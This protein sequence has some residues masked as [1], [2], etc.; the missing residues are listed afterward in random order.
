MYKTCTV[1]P[2][3]NFRYVFVWLTYRAINMSG[4]W[5]RPV[6]DRNFNF[7]ELL[8]NVSSYTE[9]R[10]CS[11]W[12]F[13]VLGGLSLTALLC[14]CLF[15]NYRLL[16]LFPESIRLNDLKLRRLNAFWNH[17]LSL[18]R[19]ISPAGALFE[20]PFYLQT[21]SAHSSRLLIRWK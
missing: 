21:R 1:E 14:L 8:S 4:P 19:F 10:S 11:S 9:K 6:Y 20:I 15:P 12:A 5:D 2:L 3:T 13:P 18:C 16:L 17:A 7:K